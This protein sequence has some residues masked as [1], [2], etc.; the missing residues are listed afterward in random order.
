[1]NLIKLPSK[2]FSLFTISILILGFIVFFDT[3][4]A[5][6]A[7]QLVLEKVVDVNKNALQETLVDPSNLKDIFPDYIK[8]VESTKVQDNKNLAKLVLGLNGFNVNSEVEYTKLPNENHIVEVITGDLR[9]TKLTTTLKETWGFDGTP[10]QGTIVNIKMTLQ[11]SGILSFLGLL[12]NEA[13]LYSL[14]YSLGNIVSYTKDPTSNIS[15]IENQSE[16]T[17]YNSVVVEET[18]STNE[19]TKNGHRRR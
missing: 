18:K 14:D 13:F 11:Y 9:G 7:R 5:A 4:E 19:N 10:N 3:Q 17:V 16:S 15:E 12:S 2:L 6:A 1:V 8:S